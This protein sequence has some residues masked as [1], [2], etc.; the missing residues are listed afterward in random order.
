MLLLKDTIEIKTSPESI[1][2]W[3][4]QLDRNYL[5]WHSRDHLKFEY[6]NGKQPREGSF[7]YFEEYVGKLVVK[8]K[9]KITKMEQDHLIE[10]TAVSFPY[11][12][13]G[14]KGAFIIEAKKSGSLFTAKISLGR[15]K[16]L[17]GWILDLI[18]K[19]IFAK[20][21]RALQTH[22]FDE[23]HNLKKLLEQ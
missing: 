9:C 4:V 3:F 17:V 2:N 8:T 7:F 1:F 5:A 16:L 23:G 13:V 19:S 6:I 22:M 20:T 10:Y 12:I 18:A 15:K 11:N 21:I 14:V